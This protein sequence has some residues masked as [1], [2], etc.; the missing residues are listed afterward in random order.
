MSDTIIYD[1][2]EYLGSG[3]WKGPNGRVHK[4]RQVYY[5]R[6]EDGRES[7]EFDGFRETFEDAV[8]ALETQ[9][10]VLAND[11]AS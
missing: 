6:A 10:A 3:Q 9:A 8:M 1:L 7:T 11:T 4:K 5:F 2:Y